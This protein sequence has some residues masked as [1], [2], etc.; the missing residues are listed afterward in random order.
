M[1]TLEYP[2]KP[3]PWAMGLAALFFAACA[4]TMAY[5]ALTNNRGLILNGIIEFSPRGAVIFYWSVAGVSALFVL[6]GVLGVLMGLA[7]KQRLRLTSTE[8][9]APRSVFSRRVTVVALADIEAIEVQTVQKQRFMNI[10]HRQGK[11]SIAQSML[12]SAQEFDALLG[13]LRERVSPRC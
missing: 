6:T 12:P 9:A 8:L 1:E 10:R 3:K 13:A 4:L 2:Y 11:L 7:G 5:A